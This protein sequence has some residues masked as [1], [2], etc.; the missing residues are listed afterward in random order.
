MCFSF[1]WKGEE[2]NQD[3]DGLVVRGRI[4]LLAKFIF[5]PEHLRKESNTVWMVGI[6]VWG[7]S[8]N[9][10][11]IRKKRGPHVAL[12]KWDSLNGGC[13]AEIS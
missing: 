1:M 7:G 8:K 10:Y 2:G 11:I 3:R 13:G 5:R 9:Q 12:P 6:S 4:S